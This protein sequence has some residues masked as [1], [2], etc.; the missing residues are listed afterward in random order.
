MN[1]LV[2]LI[3]LG[4]ALYVFS[5]ALYPSMVRFFYNH[6]FVQRNFRGD[7]V[8]AGAGLW[9]AVIHLLLLPWTGLFPSQ[10]SQTG[11][12][13][14]AQTIA[15]LVMCFAGWIDDRH[16]RKDVKGLRGHFSSI[17][18]GEV[19]TGVVKAVSGAWISL[20]LTLSLSGTGTVIEL[21]LSFIIILFSINLINLFDLRP[22]RAWKVSFF[23]VGM[24]IVTGG[25]VEPVLWL[26]L[27][28]TAVLLY[29][30]D[31][32]GKVMLGDTGANAIGVLIGYWVVMFTP[33]SFQWLWLFFLI[34]VHWYAAHYSI[35][36]L[37][38][39]IKPLRLL[40]QWGREG[41]NT[42]S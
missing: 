23:S 19:T 29:I 18:K 12:I 33:E 13:L 26:P 27:I 2:R 31:L 21:L 22:G 4:T 6:G 14:S 28:I 35:T 3:F 9:L 17:K 1:D 42:E 16:G 11:D 40:D 25:V 10:V 37:I 36:T 39:Q 30:P 24:I 7:M 34:G 8:P 5:W 32:K 38:Q 41:D 20:L 15:V